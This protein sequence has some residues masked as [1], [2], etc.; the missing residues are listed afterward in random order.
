VTDAATGNPVAEYRYYADN[1]RAEKRVFSE[2]AP[3]VLDDATAFFWDGWRCCEEQDVGTGETETT[4]VWSPV[5]VDELVQFERTA[6]HELGAGRFWV[7]QDARADVVAITDAA[8]SVVERRFYD[9]F[10]RLLDAQKEPTTESVTGLEYGFQGRRLDAETGLV[11][12]RNRYYD[13][14]T[15]RFLQRDPV[16]DAGNVGGW[17]TF[18]GNGPWSGLDPLGLDEAWRDYEAGGGVVTVTMRYALVG[19]VPRGGAFDDPRNEIEPAGDEGLSHV[20]SLFIE[21]ARI[22]TESSPT[23]VDP[24][25]GEEFTVRFQIDVR[26]GSVAAGY[27]TVFVYQQPNEMSERHFTQRERFFDKDAGISDVLHEFGHAMYIVSHEASGLM[28]SGGGMG[29]RSKDA[30]RLHQSHYRWLAWIASAPDDEARRAR[31]AALT[32]AQLE[33]RKSLGTNCP[34]NAVDRDVLRRINRE[35]ADRGGTYRGVSVNAYYQLYM[36]MDYNPL[37][38]VAAEAGGR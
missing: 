19:A 5:Y 6:A 3:G 9:D 11:Y 8:G 1:R 17:Y 18:V 30:W 37:E 27:R 7:H 24:C 38:G 35:A 4:Y 20:R 22:L 23:F 2:T 33:T 13:P 25:T 34:A 31:L 10:G 36:H 32:I 14:G 26:K 28:A 21:A 12:F 16:W 29:G 15:G